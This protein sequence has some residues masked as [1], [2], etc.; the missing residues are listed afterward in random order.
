[1]RW[2]MSRLCIELLRLIMFIMTGPCECG[3]GTCRKSRGVLLL[4]A[5]WGCL[6]RRWE[7]ERVSGKGKGPRPPEK[8]P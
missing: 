8:M 4:K 7:Y 5:R 6:F 3:D 2:K 1:M